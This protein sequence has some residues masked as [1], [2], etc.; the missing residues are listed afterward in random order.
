MAI[1]D[2]VL[3]SIT[4]SIEKITEATEAASAAVESANEGLEAAT[5]FGQ[6]GAIEIM[7]EIKEKLES[8]VTELGSV[9]TVTEEVQETAQSFAAAT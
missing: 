5:A 9:K 4:S 7:S 1:I 8:V 6:V 2:D 3:A